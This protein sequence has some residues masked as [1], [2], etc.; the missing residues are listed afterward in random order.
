M[1]EKFALITGSCD[2]IGLEIAK[3]FAEKKINLYFVSRDKKKLSTTLS[4]FKKRY[5]DIKIQG[6][7]GDINTEVF[8]NKL[9]KIKK[10]NYLINCA[11]VA[12]KKHFLRSDRND[13]DTVYNINVK[14]LFFISQ[15]VSKIMKKNKSKSYII[16][17]GS[18]LGLVGNYNRVLYSSSKFAV[19]GITKSM[20]LD[21][22]KFKINVN[23]IAPTKV[24][25][26]QNE[27]KTR[28]SIIRNKIP[29]KKFPKAR[30]IAE[31]CYF[32]CSGKVDSA[33]GST[34]VVDGGWTIF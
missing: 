26:K 18:T 31:V 13:F 34:I 27:N 7:S 33:T 11:A 21:L 6:I 17:L 4:F 19:E 25:T 1:I 15:A 16:N 3:K 5:S 30:E 23:C 8:L 29:Q 10:I 2:G 20:A 32:L 9:K 22:I 24:I 28:L 12:N 14:A